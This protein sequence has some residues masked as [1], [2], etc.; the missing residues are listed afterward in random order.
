MPVKSDTLFHNFAQCYYIVNSAV[1]TSSMCISR[2]FI[3]S[4]NEVFLYSLI[5]GEV[6]IIKTGLP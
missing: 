4:K 2:S 3:E 5:D 6:C 1:Y